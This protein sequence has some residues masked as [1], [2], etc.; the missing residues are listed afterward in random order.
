MGAFAARPA[1]HRAADNS[2][3]STWHRPTTACKNSFCSLLGVFFPASIFLHHAS[4][5]RFSKPTYAAP[6]S[7][8]APPCST[9]RFL[10][11]PPLPPTGK[12]TTECFLPAS[13][14]LHGDAS[15]FHRDHVVLKAVCMTS[16]FFF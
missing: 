7:T 15:R 2:D 4:T 13:V 14:A 3:A 10:L 8:T 5:E 12:F 16:V 9:F 1:P 11:P 6:C